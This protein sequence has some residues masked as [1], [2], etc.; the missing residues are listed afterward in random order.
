MD[1]DSITRLVATFGPY[2]A[3]FIGW[4]WREQI[5][6]AIHRP[7]YKRF[8]ALEDSLGKK[9]DATNGTLTAHS[10]EDIARFKSTDN[11]LRNINR[12]LP[13]PPKEKP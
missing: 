7:I 9:I 6:A 13:R 1:I 12:R 4:F 2:V 11:R 3:G 8:D 5:V 10:L